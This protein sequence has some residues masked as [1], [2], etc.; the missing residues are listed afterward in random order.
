MFA[1][2]VVVAICR[3]FVRRHVE[4]RND[5]RVVRH[6]RW[7]DRNERDGLIGASDEDVELAATLVSRLTDYVAQTEVTEQRGEAHNSRVVYVTEMYAQNSTEQRNSCGTRQKPSRRRQT[8]S[9]PATLAADTAAHC[10]QDGGAVAKSTYYWRSS[11][12]EPSSQTARR[13]PTYTFR[14]STTAQPTES[15]HRLRQTLVQLCRNEDLEQSS[16]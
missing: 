8:A 3:L 6:R 10:L 16:H 9:P 11:I 15:V 7:I 5:Q 12:P 2:V 4:C 1:S 14:R 13:H